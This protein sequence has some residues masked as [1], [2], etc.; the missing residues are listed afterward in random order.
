MA[1]YILKRMMYAIGTLFA[2]ATILFFIFRLMPGDPATTVINP[3]M[4]AAAQARLREA[5]GVDKPLLT[6]YA[7]YLK[8][9]VT[10]EWGRSFNTAQPVSEII[11]Y[12]L[13]N[14]LLLMTGG[15]LIA[16]VL[17]LTLGIV[18]AWRRN[19][20]LD[21]VGTV[22]ALIFQSA[23]PFVTGLLLLIVFSYTLN[24]FP[25]GGMIVA[26]GGDPGTIDLLTRADFY[27]HLALPTAAIAIYY[28]ATP[29]LVMRDSML[30]VIGADYVDLARAKG[31][32]PA[33]VFIRHAARNA[34][35]SIVTVISILTAFAIGG[36]VVVETLFSWPGMGQLL[37][38][39][40]SQH[41]YPVAQGSFLVLAC[42]VI[43]MNLFADILYCVI[44]PR[45]Q[46]TSG[47]IA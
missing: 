34:L 18:L 41:D 21:V 24:L 13:G 25:T 27:H 3:N 44:D 4:D 19:S 1:P 29:M 2:V 45:I 16:I 22:S 28:L 40:A 26:G 6:Q 30:D 37:V 39:A 32:S 11:A 33:G 23:P 42:I 17:G 8:N 36:Q 38:Q 9:T 15:V 7:I 47:G 43:F 46:V 5:F 14:T 31:V 10:F 12:R 35:L 20:M